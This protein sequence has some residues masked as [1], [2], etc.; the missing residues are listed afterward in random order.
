MANKDRFE[1]GQVD[2][3]ALVLRL[4]EQFKVNPARP[5]VSSLERLFGMSAM[6]EGFLDYLRR[7]SKAGIAMNPHL[8][9]LKNKI[10]RLSKN[11]G[12]VYSCYD[13]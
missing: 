12:S 6:V 9:R 4:R 1:S 7:E 10:K 13:L 5:D 11:P 8:E 3:R 2:E